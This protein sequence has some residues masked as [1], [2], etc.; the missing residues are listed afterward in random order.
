M[1]VPQGQSTPWPQ[2]GSAGDPA[3]LF[4]QLIQQSPVGIALLDADGVLRSVNPAYCAIHGYDE[5]AL[6]GQHFTM[7][8]APTLHAQLSARHRAFLA[9][10]ATAPATTAE[11]DMRRGDGQPLSVMAQSLRVHDAAGQPARLVYVMDISARRR[12]EQALQASRRFLHSVLD[13]LTSHVCVLDAGGR[14]MAVNRA[15]REFAQANGG[16]GETVNEGANYLAACEHALQD[17]ALPEHAGLASFVRQ[18]RQVLAGELASVQYEYASHAPGQRRWFVARVSQITGSQPPRSVVAHDDVTALKLAQET[19]SERGAL[20]LDL[21]GS[22]PGALFRLVCNAAGRWQFVY[23][24]PGV[25]PLFGLTPAQ[26]C[27]DIRALG[28]HILPED[29]PAHDLSIREAV[30]HLRPWRHEYRIRSTDGQLKWVHSRASA[31][32]GA[33]GVVVWTGLLTDISER[34]HLQSVLMDSEERYR[35]L[36]ETVAQGVVYQ[37]ANGRITSANPSAQRI[38]GLTLEQLQG[39]ESIDAQ[40]QALR[41]DGSDFPVDEHP[42]MVALRTGQPVR[43]VVM[44]VAVP[45]R[46]HAWLLLNATPLFRQ[47]RIHEV[48]ASFEDIT[49]RVL[50]SRELR[51][52]ASTDY[53]TKVANR[54]GLMERLQLEFELMQQHPTRRCAVLAADL[55][56]FKHVNDNHGHAAGDAVL[57][58]VAQLMLQITRATDLVAR[59]GGEEFTLLLPEMDAAE[60]MAMAER[61]R[62]RLES[63]PPLHGGRAL[64]VTVSIGVSLFAAGDAGADT[65]L[66]RAD[67]ALYQ[68]K[69]AGRNQV[70]L[71]VLPR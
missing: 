33:D 24:S 12:A 6:L 38:L 47:G 17:Q 42:S 26:A 65:A 43:D 27:G 40:W 68:A 64:A 54:R 5:Q 66:L 49:E 53:L 41:E 45:G 70:R 10:G 67:Q 35:T 39:I 19:L 18:L 15:W 58:H 20:L 1:Q 30:A 46:G 16:L 62:Q 71:A 44:G 7:L 37:S 60:A 32:T 51:L 56:F 52:Q 2:G 28:A 23:F 22:I 36:F 8:F 31:K 63:D 21:A 9:D 25:E 11:W 61:L 29:R 48:Y 59:S 3:G 14:V 13:G 69:Q 4:Q 34:K 57:Q 50:M 55:D